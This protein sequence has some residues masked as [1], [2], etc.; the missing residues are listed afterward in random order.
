MAVVRAGNKGRTEPWA[1]RRGILEP[2]YGR[3]RAVLATRHRPLYKMVP[4][5]YVL[6]RCHTLRHGPPTLPRAMDI[7]RRGKG[8]IHQVRLA[9]ICSP[10]VYLHQR[11]GYVQ[12]KPPYNGA[13]AL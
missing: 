8:D 12:D 10:A 13:D 1:V 4:D 2:L 9:E 3:I 6:A 11:M 7:R 5:G